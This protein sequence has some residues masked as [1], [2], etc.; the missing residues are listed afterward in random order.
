MGKKLIYPC[1]KKEADFDAIMDIIA[2]NTYMASTCPTIECPDCGKEITIYL[3]ID[4]IGE[5]TA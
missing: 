5:A 4:S 3:D 2:D 1:C